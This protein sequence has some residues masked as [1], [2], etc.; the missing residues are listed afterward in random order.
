MFLLLAFLDFSPDDG[1]EAPEDQPQ[2]KPSG[3]SIG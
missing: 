1:A 3:Y 2:D